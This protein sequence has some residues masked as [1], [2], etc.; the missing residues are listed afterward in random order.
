VKKVRKNRYTLTNFTIR[1]CFNVLS[2]DISL[3]IRGAMPSS[4]VV[5][6]IF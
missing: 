5:A 2:I 4:S 1:S 6:L 3:K